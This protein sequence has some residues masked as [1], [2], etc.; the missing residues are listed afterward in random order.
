MVKSL[1]LGL[2]SAV[3]VNAQGDSSLGQIQK[4]VS[5][6]PIMCGVFDQQ[7]TLVG[8]KRPVRSSG[9]F[10]VVAEKGVLWN[11]LTPFASTLRLTRE[12]IVQSQGERVTSR[13]SSREEPTVGVISE[14]LFSVLAGD[15]KRLQSGFKI[16]AAA[17]PATWRARLVPK[18]SGMRRVISA[19]EL[20]GSDYVRQLTL[21]EASGDRTTIS[22][23]DMVAGRSALQPEE[24]RAF[25]MTATSGGFER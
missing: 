1:L 9:R 2:L 6:P 24:A 11:T 16:D 23:T 18:E 10:C 15:F 25:G 17:Q 5:R 20:S 4:L 22:F 12:E 14:L 13:L 7:K 3:S 8:L 19:I 21:F